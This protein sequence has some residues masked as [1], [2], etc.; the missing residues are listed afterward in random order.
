MSKVKLNYT[1]FLDSIPVSSGTVVTGWYPGN[2]GS[3]ETDGELQV[4]DGTG[5]PMFLIIDYTDELASPPTGDKVTCLYGQGKVVVQP[6][7]VT[8]WPN[9]YVG[10]LADWDAN[11]PIYV[12]TSGLLTPHYNATADTASGSVQ[13]GKVFDPP[14]ASNDY[15]LTMLVT[16]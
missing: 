3:L 15:E 10:A 1:G 6:D 5:D 13:V 9:V 11:D 2:V 7:D 8:D 12:T 14:T 4:Y 16:L